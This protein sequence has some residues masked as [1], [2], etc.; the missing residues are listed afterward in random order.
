M[1]GQEIAQS[2]VIFTQICFWQIPDQ[3]SVTQITFT[4]LQLTITQL[5][6]KLF[7]IL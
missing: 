3:P 5:L 7:W 6:G 2:W 1:V 4:Q